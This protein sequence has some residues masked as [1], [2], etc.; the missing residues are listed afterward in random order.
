MRAGG[1]RL[2][3]AALVCLLRALPVT[4]ED[5]APGAAPDVE[6]AAAGDYDPWHSFNERTFAFNFNILDR[7]VMKPLGHAWDWLLPDQVQRSLDNAFANLEMPRRCVNHLLQVR[8]RA[9]GV[10]VG[11]FLV[12]TTAGVVGLFDVADRIGLHGKD[13]DSG[14]TFGVWGIGPGP[15][16][17]LPFFAPF[18]VRDA[19]GQAADS[20]LDPVGYL[21]PVPLAVSLSMTAVR[22]VNGRS[23]QPAAFENVED[24]VIDVYS[25][26]RNAYLQ[27][28]QAAI[29]EGRA[30]SAC[31]YLRSRAGTPPPASP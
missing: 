27:R 26:V 12:N 6:A 22:R 24:T 2:L 19:I 5:V 7:Y 15:Y 17:V 1:A 13:A 25:S 23:L 21:F 9:A 11:R 28:R 18:N 10:E 29:L 8:P 31:P 16:L 3:V 4:A 20:A 14:Q 30:D